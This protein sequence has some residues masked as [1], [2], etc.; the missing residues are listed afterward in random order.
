MRR[1]R[2]PQNSGRLKPM[3]VSKSRRGKAIVPG[4][5]RADRWHMVHASCD[6]C[7][8]VTWHFKHVPPPPGAILHPTRNVWV[9]QCGACRYAPLTLV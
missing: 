5:E 2:K 8:I 1:V 7:D 3:P 9:V 6:H 4:V